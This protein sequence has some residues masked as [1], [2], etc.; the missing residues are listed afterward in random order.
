M[1]TLDCLK[2]VLEMGEMERVFEL[3]SVD[4]LANL[5]ASFVQEW[6]TISNPV[7]IKIE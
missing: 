7:E 1:E 5:V 3:A 6:G 4:W 2:W